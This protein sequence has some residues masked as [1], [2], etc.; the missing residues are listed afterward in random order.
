M[1]P[2]NINKP[3]LW[4]ILLEPSFLCFFS[5]IPL[6]K[7]FFLDLKIRKRINLQSIQIKILHGRYHR[8]ICQSQ[9]QTNQN[10][11]SLQQ[12]NHHHHHS[13]LLLLLAPLH[14]T[15]ALLIEEICGFFLVLDL[16]LH[17]LRDYV[18]YFLK[19]NRSH[20]FSVKASKL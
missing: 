18:L 12:Y 4:R 11:Q 7:T 14:L 15:N 19:F 9:V 16:I 20:N 17:E 2:R 1:S 8:N 3:F 6:L 13:Y 10:H 5:T